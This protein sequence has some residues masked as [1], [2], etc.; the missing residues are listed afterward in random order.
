MLRVDG[1]G[2]MLSICIGEEYKLGEKKEASIDEPVQSSFSFGTISRGLHSFMESW[3][4]LDFAEQLSRRDKNIICCYA[5]IPKGAEYWE[6]RWSGSK[7]YV[8]SELIVTKIIK[9]YKHESI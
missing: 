1:D 9:E 6:G 2:K 3:E 7:N 8:S 5:I 4:A